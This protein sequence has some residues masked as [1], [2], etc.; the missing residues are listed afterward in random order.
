MSILKKNLN[1]IGHDCSIANPE[2]GSDLN[3][4]A[5]NNT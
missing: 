1:L 2:I 3:Y 5:Y 4:Y